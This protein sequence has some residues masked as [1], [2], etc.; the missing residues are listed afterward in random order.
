M[1]EQ[2]I[3]ELSLGTHGLRMLVRGEDVVEDKADPNFLEMLL[4]DLPLL[5][6]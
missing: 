2:G 1:E 4:V 6:G 5:E 3:T